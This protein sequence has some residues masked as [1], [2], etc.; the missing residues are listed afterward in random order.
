MENIIKLIQVNL[1]ENYVIKK[2]YSIDLW[3][4]FGMNEWINKQIEWS[5][6]DILQLN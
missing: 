5:N 1:I 4:N 6:N 2:N 3:M